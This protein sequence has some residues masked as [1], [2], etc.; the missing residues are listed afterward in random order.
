MYRLLLVY[1]QI[2]ERLKRKMN[3]VFTTSIKEDSTRKS[4]QVNL[5]DVGDARAVELQP[6]SDIKPN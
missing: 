5:S 4:P 6:R 1:L 2:R 3:G